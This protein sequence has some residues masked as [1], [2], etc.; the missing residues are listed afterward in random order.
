VRYQQSVPLD[1]DSLS[2]VTC[3]FLMLLMPL[4]TT[5]WIRHDLVRYTNIY[6]LD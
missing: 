2:L 4:V 1:L 3:G 5:A 6:P